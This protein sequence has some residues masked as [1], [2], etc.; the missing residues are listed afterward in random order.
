MSKRIGPSE[1]SPIGVSFAHSAQYQVTD[2]WSEVVYKM[3]EAAK[4][5]LEGMSVEH[6]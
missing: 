2:R 5:Q 4:Q 6:P 3:K 1:S